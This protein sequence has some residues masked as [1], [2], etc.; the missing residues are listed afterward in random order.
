MNFGGHI[1]HINYLKLYLNL[2]FVVLED[3][4]QSVEIGGEDP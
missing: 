4:R 1:V 2:L 3:V